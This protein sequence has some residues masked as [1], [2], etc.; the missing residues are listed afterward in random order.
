MGISEILHQR[1][2]QITIPQYPM[3]AEPKATTIQQITNPIEYTRIAPY[4]KRYHIMYS[5]QIT[6]T[7]YSAKLIDII[8]NINHSINTN[9]PNIATKVS[10]TTSYPPQKIA[11][12]N[13]NLNIYTDGSLKNNHT[14]QRAGG[15]G[16]HIPS[17]QLSIHRKLP[18][19]KDATHCEI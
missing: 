18:E 19:A 6:Q 13:T 12:T 10:R 8:Q 16:I 2:L 15:A 14:P 7:K 17:L 11:L 5:H 3:I 4:L 9:Q 1:D